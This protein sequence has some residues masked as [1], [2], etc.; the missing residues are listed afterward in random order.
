[1]H[2]LE[3]LPKQGLFILAVLLCL[4]FGLVEFLSGHELSFSILYVLPVF[5]VAWYLGEKPAFF[6]SLLSIL[7]WLITDFTSG[8]AYSHAA[9]P[10]WNATVRLFFFFGAACLLAEIKRLLLRNTALSLTDALTGAANRRSF[11]E[12]ISSEIN[13][14]A[15]FNRPLT[16]A[17]LDIDD[18]KH[19]NDRYGHAAGDALLIT[20]VQTVKKSIRSVD[21]IARLGG[22]EFAILLPETGNEQSQIVV[23]KIRTALSGA[24]AEN[25]WPVTL[26]FGVVTMP[27]SPGCSSDE[28]INAAD[29]LNVFC[30]KTRGK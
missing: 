22:D 15:R 24:A 6:I 11:A 4:L 20:V 12:I 14:S 19:I 29:R 16:L 18:F 1:M 26:S 25:A 28:L 23:G 17:Y 5:L 8:H 10:F 30:E 3:N 9:I 2:M 27:G 7:I 13:K 21:I